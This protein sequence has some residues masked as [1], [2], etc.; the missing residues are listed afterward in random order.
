[1]FGE[2]LGWNYYQWLLFVFY[3]ISLSL[4][5]IGSKLFFNKI[6]IENYAIK[7]DLSDVG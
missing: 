7:D 1:M 3:I 6:V 5:S 4:L 2:R